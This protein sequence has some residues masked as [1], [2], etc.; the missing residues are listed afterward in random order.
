MATVA[1]TQGATLALTT[2][3]VGWRLAAM[4]RAIRADMACRGYSSMWGGKRMRIG[5]F[6][7]IGIICSNASPCQEKTDGSLAWAMH[8]PQRSDHYTNWILPFLC[9]LSS[10]PSNVT[11]DLGVRSTR[12]RGFWVIIV[13]AGGLQI[14]LLECPCRPLP[15]V[16]HAS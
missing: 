1:G 3:V 5:V 4:K 10:G 11:N 12:C 8:S 14:A 6:L 9:W 15:M 2:E 7:Q 13:V 16:E